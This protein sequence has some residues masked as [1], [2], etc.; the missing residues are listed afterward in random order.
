MVGSYPGQHFRR[1]RIGKIWE[2]P[3]SARH[4]AAGERLSSYC[5]SFLLLASLMLWVST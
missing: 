3:L 4:Q 1:T 2:M 5:F